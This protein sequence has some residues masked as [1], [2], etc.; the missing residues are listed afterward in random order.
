MVESG[1]EKGSPSH[2]QAV[3][4]KGRGKTSHLE[5]SSYFLIGTERKKENK[6]NEY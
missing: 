3:K 1:G 2:I 4:R 5:S 6:F